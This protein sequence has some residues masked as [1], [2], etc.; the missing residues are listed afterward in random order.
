MS[1][2]CM[3]EICSVCLTEA[4]EK[5]GLKAATLQLLWSFKRWRRYRKYVV[6]QYRLAL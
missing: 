2:A 4:M 1:H 6:K 5:T 3:R